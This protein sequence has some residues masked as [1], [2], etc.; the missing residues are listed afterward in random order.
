M[1][2][3]VSDGDFMFVFITGGDDAGDGEFWFVKEG[4]LRLID[5]SS[6]HERG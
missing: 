2:R 4:I 6:L 3:R 5:T 1:A